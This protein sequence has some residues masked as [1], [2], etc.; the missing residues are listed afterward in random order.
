VLGLPQIATFPLPDM[1]KDSVLFLWRVASM[2]AEALQV[3]NSWGY[4]LKTELVW[5]KLTKHGKPFFGMGRTVRAAHEVC[6]IGT[7]GRPK[8]K[9]RSIRSSFSA[10]VRKH[11]EKPEEFYSIVEA[12][13]PGPYAELFA[14]RERPGWD[15]WG[16]ELGRPHPG[17]TQ[18]VLMP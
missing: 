6:L 5:N 9:T 4:R 13:F 16:D 11:S 18:L 7:K 14:R 8:V 1:E 2:Q 12:L 17:P 3:M 10:Q 15:C